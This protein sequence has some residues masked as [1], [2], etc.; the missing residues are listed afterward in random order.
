MASGI[1]WEKSLNEF[2]KQK[3][4]EEFLKIEKIFFFNFG[5]NARE[6]YEIIHEIIL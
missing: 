1:F 4:L 5:R 3:P 2:L 6:V